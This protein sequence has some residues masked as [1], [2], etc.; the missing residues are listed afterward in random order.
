MGKGS[1][2]RVPDPYSAR[3][4]PGALSLCCLFNQQGALMTFVALI[5][6]RENNG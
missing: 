2:R 3:Q 6:L 5:V 1:D 4:K